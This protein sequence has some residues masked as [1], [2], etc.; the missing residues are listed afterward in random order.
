MSTD[1]S[2]FEFE[3]RFLVREL[4]DQL[5][6]AP[7]LVVQSYYLSDGG[8][9]L[10]VRVQATDVEARL[11][12]ESDPRMV[13]DAYRDKVDFAAVTVK[14]P[15][16]GGTRY[17]AE[18]ELDPLVAVEL[19]ARGGARVLKTRYAAWLGADGWS[20]DVFGSG[21]HPLIV[22]ECERSSPVTELQ[23]PD[24]C[25]T[26]LTDDRRFSNESLAVHPYREWSARYAAEL[27]ASGPRFRGDFGENTRLTTD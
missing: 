17:E 1:Y 19:V 14:G 10:R 20:L 27:A 15:S 13:L 24:F 16:A 26:E 18:R 25:V 23:I 5:R 7:S 3:R 2:D 9:A 8:Y 6:D 12:A 22:A 4:P 21:N 11:D